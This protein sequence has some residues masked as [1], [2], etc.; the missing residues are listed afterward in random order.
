MST[1]IEG[2]LD[3]K[4]DF[5]EMC[6]RSP[7]ACEF[8]NMISYYALVKCDCNK[9]IC[10]LCIRPFENASNIFCKNC[11]S[12][13][14]YKTNWV[15]KRCSQCNQNRIHGDKIP[16]GWCGTDIDSRLYW[17]NCHTCKE[18]MCSHCRVICENDECR[19]Q[20]C[21]ITCGHAHQ[22]LLVRGFHIC[23][24]CKEEKSLV[25][26]QPNKCSGKTEE[27]WY[28]CLDC[29]NWI[30]NECSHEHCVNQEQSLRSGS[31]RSL[32]VLTEAP[33]DI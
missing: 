30:C 6:R 2:P 26:P 12:N 1:P 9:W 4:R 14:S 17:T 22:S 29:K 7:L 11:R 27:Y 23:S 16:G 31:D 18:A 13:H 5:C 33:K 3:A 10:N 8:C 15:V 21:S 32:N 28:Q 19:L 25:V 20:F 24:E